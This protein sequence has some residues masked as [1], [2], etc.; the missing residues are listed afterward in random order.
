MTLTRTDGNAALGS[1]DR[2][3]SGYGLTLAGIWLALSLTEQGR[4]DE[5]RAILSQI[6]E[7]DPPSLVTYALV[8]SRQGKDGGYARR[9]EG[10]R[11]CK[12]HTY[13]QFAE[14]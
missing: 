10:Q 7:P 12:E 11:K 3:L 1:G 2:Y 8:E 5:A 9:D 14:P 4:L 13:S 6:P